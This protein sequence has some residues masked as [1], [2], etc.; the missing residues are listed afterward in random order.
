MPRRTLRVSA[1]AAV[2]ALAATAT[3]RPAVAQPGAN[4]A[5]ADALFDEG[6]ALRNAGDR[7]AACDRFRQSYRLAAARGTLLN[8]AEFFEAE[9]LLASA[10][11][12]YRTL[13][14]EAEA[15][16]DRERLAIARTKATE[17]GPRLAY[18]TVVASGAAA[19]ADLEVRRDGAR[20]PAGTLGQAIPID[21]GVH[22]L[23]VSAAGHHGWST[24]VEIVDGARRRVEIPALEPM[25]EPPP[26][27]PPATADD[28]VTSSRRRHPRATA[29]LVMIAGGSLSAAVGLGFGTAAWR[30]GNDADPHCDEALMCSPYGAERME[31]A[32]RLAGR[33]NVLVGIGA[34]V[35]VAG[36]VLWWTAPDGA[37]VSVAPVAGPGVVGVTIGGRL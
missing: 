2:V 37:E 20:L 9:G 36:A 29:G 7:A 3:T 24:Q 1:L 27:P 6:V 10:W 13:A 5:A 26:S 35:A 21:A 31:D 34:A 11:A 22:T 23:E 14:D 25:P 8:I 17:L 32:R 16:G 19:I 18:L 4:D 12:A 28:R 30:A 33:A 15:A